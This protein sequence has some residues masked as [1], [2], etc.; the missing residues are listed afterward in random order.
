MVFVL[1]YRSVGDYDAKRHLKRFQG[2]KQ[3]LFRQNADFISP[4]KRERGVL[5][6]SLCLDPATGFS[7][8]DKS[9]KD[10]ALVMMDRKYINLQNQ[11]KT[12]KFQEFL[13]DI[14]RSS[15]ELLDSM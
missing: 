11:V 1:E 8:A 5:R 7:Y 3:S 4:E 10:L 14:L 13:T 6:L 2:L 15:S 9:I 12:A